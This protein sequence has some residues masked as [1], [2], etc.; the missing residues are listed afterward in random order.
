MNQKKYSHQRAKN[1]TESSRKIASNWAQIG[2]ENEGLKHY[3]AARTV[4][5]PNADL[6]WSNLLS[7]CSELF[8]VALD[9]VMNP[10]LQTKFKSDSK[11]LETG[12]E[13]SL[14]CYYWTKSAQLLNSG[15]VN[16][17]LA[18][19][20]RTGFGS[21]LWIRP[22]FKPDWLTGYWIRSDF[23]QTRMNPI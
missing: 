6:W 16:P 2:A 3:S 21:V 5:A 20:K 4:L 9:W 17:C 18:R 15:R 19:C 23:K 12:T 11:G 14:Y 22:E 13:M 1:L 10:T 8:P 7:N